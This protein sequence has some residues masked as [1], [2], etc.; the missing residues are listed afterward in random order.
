MKLHIGGTEV[1]DGWKILNA[2][3]FPG[4]D[5]VGDISNLG[6][7]ADNSVEQIYASHVLE[8]VGQAA[9]RY[10]LN[11][12]HRILM[13]GGKFMVSVPDLDILC[14]TF[15]SP[16]AD[17]NMKYHVLNMIYGGQSDAYDFH[18]MGFN[19]QFLQGF[20]Q[21]AGFVD[22]RRVASFGLFADFSE[23]KPYGFPISL[24]LVAAK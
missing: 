24:N 15:I 13:K 9:M 19:A 18:Y 23:F 11:G 17:A 16:V 6:Q 8:H 7:F 3:K 14:H 4:V 1:K 5:Y 2:Q 10:T 21:D 22:I 20:L 12:I